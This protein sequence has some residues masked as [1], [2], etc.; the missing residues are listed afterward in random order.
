[1]PVNI[2]VGEA[3]SDVSLREEHVIVSG[4]DDLDRHREALC[5]MWRPWAEN[6]KER[7]T[8]Y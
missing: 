5:L 6:F 3:F 4:W 1:M 8:Q 7:R 2:A